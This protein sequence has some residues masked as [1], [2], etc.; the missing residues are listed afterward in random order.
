MSRASLAPL[1]SLE[2]T[3]WPALAL[4]KYRVHHQMR[5]QTMPLLFAADLNKCRL[6]PHHN[7]ELVEA[8][9][10]ASGVDAT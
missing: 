3:G 6:T 5:K 7:T 9:I 1:A 4:W 8:L 2:A 10:V